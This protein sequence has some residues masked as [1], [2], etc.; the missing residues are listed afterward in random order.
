MTILKGFL[1][2]FLKTNISLHELKTEEKARESKKQKKKHK[3]VGPKR[4]KS[5]RFAFSSMEGNV[6]SEQ[7][8]QHILKN[9]RVW[10]IRPFSIH[11]NNQD[12]R[13]GRNETRGL[14]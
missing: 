1:I 9:G 11:F 12:G 7:S 5:T 14:V 10:C 6:S 2:Q 8:D 4:R 3:R 13:K